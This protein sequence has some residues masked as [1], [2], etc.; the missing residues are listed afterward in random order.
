MGSIHD[1]KTNK[2]TS[3]NINDFS[4]V[5]LGCVVYQK[6]IK[7]RKAILA[8]IFRMAKNG[9]IKFVSKISNG[10]LK[11]KADISVNIVSEKNL[12]SE[13]KIII[14]GLKKHKSLKSFFKDNSLYEKIIKDTEKILKKEELISEANIQIRKRIVIFSFVFFFIPAVLIGSYGIIK[15]RP[16]AYGFTLFLIIAGLGRLIKTSTIPILSRKGLGLKQKVKLYL[17]KKKMELEEEIKNN[18]SQSVNWFF[19]NL[20]YLI[21]HKKFNKKL[22]KKYKNKLKKSNEFNIPGWLELDFSQTDKN[23]DALEVIEVID[24]TIIS[25]MFIA[26][27]AGVMNGVGVNNSQKVESRDE[28]QNVNK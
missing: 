7:R 28:T 21:L 3:V 24:Y 13:Q 27:T 12:T 19:E 10:L 17:E 2:L 16:V 15:S 23:I 5:Q 9:K 26:V 25:T 4:L 6:K 14:K 18:Q 11:K 20:P 22:I 1:K 8:E